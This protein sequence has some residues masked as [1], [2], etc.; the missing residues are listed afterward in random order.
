VI[1]ILFAIFAISA[2]ILFARAAGRHVDKIVAESKD[3]YKGTSK[4][5]TTREPWDTEEEDPWK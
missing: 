5:L 4:F 3:R 1:V 2:A